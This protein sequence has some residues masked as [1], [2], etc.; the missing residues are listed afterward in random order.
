MTTAR[1]QKSIDNDLTTDGDAGESLTTTRCQKFIDN[2]L[3]TDGN[4]GGS[5][6]TERCQ[7]SI[8]N[9]LTTDDSQLLPTS[10][11][12]VRPLAQLEPELQREAWQLSVQKAG[13]KQPTNPIVKDVVQQIMQ[14]TK[15]PNTY[16][17]GE[18]CRLL[19]KNNPD[20]RGKGKYWC[21]VS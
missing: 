14:R 19:P 7:K 8:D 10:E 13:G 3:T 4:A 18:I 20:L 5:L 16:R 11:Y 2:D 9:D 1:C 6:T 17:V 21:I 15:V 12:Q